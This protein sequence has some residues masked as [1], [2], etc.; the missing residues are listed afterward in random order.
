MGGFRMYL[1]LAIRN[2]KRTKVR[3]SLAVVGIIIGV[4]AIASIGI[5]GNTMK[6]TALE[7]FSD[8][9]RIIVVMPSNIKGFTGIAEEDFKNIERVENIEY[10]IPVKD[11]RKMV[12]YKESRAYVIIYGI[13]EEDLRKLYNA[14][15]GY[16]KLKGSAV[17]GYRLASN[18]GISVGEKISVGDKIYRVSGILEYQGLGGGLSP[19]NAVFLSMEDFDRIFEKEGYTSIVVKASSLEFVKDVEKKIDELVNRKQ[20]KV[21]IRDFESLI[22]NVE[23]SMNSMTRF[24]MAIA[25]VSLLVAGVGIL[26]IMLMSTMERTREIGVMRAIGAPRKT[27]LFIFLTES[28]ILGLVGSVIGAFL[29]YLGAF[30]IISSMGYSTNY[31]FDPSSAIYIL[32]GL[33]VGIMTSILSGFYPAWKASSVEPMEALRYE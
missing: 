4:M 15:D 23:E 1:E 13:N 27:V 5:F 2:L 21:E 10:A 8:Q 20:Q 16:I 25:A 18:F 22:R 7:R 31:I 29:S 11:D 19:D 17:V 6:Q 28:A 32:Q 3:S 30:F 14:Y 24:L 9:A 12:N 33:A 26:N